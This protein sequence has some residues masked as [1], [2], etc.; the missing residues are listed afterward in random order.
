MDKPDLDKPAMTGFDAYL[1][2]I[3]TAV[4]NLTTE[5]LVSAEMVAEYLLHKIRT[6]FGY[7]EATGK[8]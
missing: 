1:E 6:E 2:P 5:E 3:L 8:L 7:R 4:P